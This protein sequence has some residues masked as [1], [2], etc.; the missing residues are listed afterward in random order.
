[1]STGIKRMRREPIR[2]ECDIIRFIDKTTGL[3][4][5]EIGTTNTDDYY[6]SFVG[7]FNPQNMAVN[8][9]R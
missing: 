6:P 9:G 1:V 7:I 3:V 5:L 4:V 2:F 8:Q